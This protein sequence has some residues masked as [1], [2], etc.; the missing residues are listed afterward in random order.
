[1]PCT[2]WAV[3]SDSPSQTQIQHID[4]A[5]SNT[6]T[7]ASNP[8]PSPFWNRNPSANP[9]VIRITIDSEYRTASPR[10]APISGADPGDRQRPE[11]VEHALGE[12]VVQRHPGAHRGEHHGLHEQ[13]G[14]QVRQIVVPGPALGDR[15]AEDEQEQH[16]EDDRLERH[17]RQGFGVL[18]DPDDVAPGQ[19]Q[20]LLRPGERPGT[21][22]RVGRGLEVAGSSSSRSGRERGRWAVLDGESLRSFT[23]RSFQDG[24]TASASAACPVRARKTSSRLGSRRASSVTAIPASSRRPDDDRHRRCRPSP[25]R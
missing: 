25:A 20:A 8:L 24:V 3:F 1:M 18:P 16:Q 21:A 4:S 13:A 19:R 15:A 11:P 10:T 14:Q 23:G 5:N 7:S 9:V 17:V 12:V 6:I 2:P 22:G